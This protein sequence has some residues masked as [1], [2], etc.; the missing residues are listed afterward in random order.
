[1]YK[2]I[3]FLSF[4]LFAEMPRPYSDIT[5]LPYEALSTESVRGPLKRILHQQEVKT[6]IEVG[7][8]LG[9]TTRYLLHFAEKGATVYAVDSWRNGTGAWRPATA[10]PYHQFLSN[11]IHNGAQEQVI[12]IRMESLEA[13]GAL[14]AI[15]A[16]LVYLNASRDFAA[17]WAD[18]DAWFPYVQKEGILCG[19]GWQVE[20]VRKAVV[21]FA[22]LH[23]V[24]VHGDENIWVIQRGASFR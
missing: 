20:E 21:Q 14:R 2:W 11:M 12:P 8:W 4:T 1:M 7:S 18:L 10:F 3:C 24:K 23:G 9:V 19:Y 6:I 15:N 5:P 17:V 22:D 13:A 16:D